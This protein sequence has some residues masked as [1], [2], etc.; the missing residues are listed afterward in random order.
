MTIEKK[1][2]II[3]LIKDNGYIDDLIHYACREGIKEIRVHKGNGYVCFY[4]DKT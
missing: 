1:E 4:T 2:H 3:Q